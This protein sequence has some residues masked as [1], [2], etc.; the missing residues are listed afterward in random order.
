MSQNPKPARRRRAITAA[1]AGL[2][3][4]AG[5]FLA[6]AVAAPD[7]AGGASSVDSV[8]QSGVE[9]YKDGKYF[10]V[11]KDAPAV[12]YTGGTQGYAPTAAPKGKFNPNSA[13]VRKY[14]KFLEK[15]QR[16]GPR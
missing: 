10:V 8:L 3:L 6:P 13:H 15:K 1:L 14:E 16:S 2:P 12:T 11:L 9:N 4:I 7:G 5:T